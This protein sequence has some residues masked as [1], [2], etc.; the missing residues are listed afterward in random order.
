MIKILVDQHKAGSL[1]IIFVFHAEFGRRNFDQILWI[2][3]DNDIHFISGNFSTKFMCDVRTKGN[4][5]SADNNNF[6]MINCGIATNALNGTIIALV[7][8]ESMHETEE[9]KETPE[10]NNN[11]PKLTHVGSRTRHNGHQDNVVQKKKI[12]HA[13]TQTHERAVNRA[14][15]DALVI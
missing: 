15:W 3:Q 12:I 4:M 9:N 6:Q 1:R 2:C 10:Q 7:R 13:H 11:Q 14:K 5:K 8:M